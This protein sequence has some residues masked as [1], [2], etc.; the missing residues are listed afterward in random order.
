MGAPSLDDHVAIT[1]LT[2]AYCWALDSHRWDDLDAVFLPDATADLASPATLQGIDAIKARV[3]SA[4]QP[5]DDSQHIVSNHQID[6][7]G[8]EG[9]C[10]CYLHA[11]H[12]R[13][14]AD[15]GPNFIIGGRYEDRVVRTA[16]GWRIAH[17]TLV[18]MWREGNP[19]VVLGAQSQPAA[20]SP[21]T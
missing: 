11:Q 20:A 14:A 12:V 18:S 2:V 9:T 1:N 5:L 7:D 17:R 15:G 4:L 19:A 10:R 21:S 13:R 16:D 6:V 3:A 8:D